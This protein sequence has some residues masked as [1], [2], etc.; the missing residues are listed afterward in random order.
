MAR[1]LSVGGTKYPL[2]ENMGYN[3]SVGAYSAFVEM[4]DGSE[5]AVVRRRG[6]PWRFWTMQDRLSA[7]PRSTGV[8]M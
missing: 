3:H 5:K 4:P 8:G 1:K 6:R 7:G 2:V